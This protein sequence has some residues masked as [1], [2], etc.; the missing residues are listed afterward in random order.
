MNWTIFF[1]IAGKVI[2]MFA[3][4]EFGKAISQAKML[5][6][7][8]KKARED[9]KITAEEVQQIVKEAENLYEAIKEVIKK[10]AEP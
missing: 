1:L 6:Q 4:A 2:K 7:A 8:I 3:S 5:R 10:T 9:G